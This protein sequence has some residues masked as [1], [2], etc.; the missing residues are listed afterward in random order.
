MIDKVDFSEKST[1]QEVLAEYRIVDTHREPMG[2]GRYEITAPAVMKAGRH[3]VGHATTQI[4]AVTLALGARYV[5]AVYEKNIEKQMDAR[6]AIDWFV[7]QV[8]K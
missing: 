1:P 7:A 4:G 6:R 5:Q 8:D 2:R 3:I